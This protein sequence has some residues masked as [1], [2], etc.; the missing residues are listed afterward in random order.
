M[1][2][3]GSR[4]LRGGSAFQHELLRPTLQPLQSAMKHASLTEISIV[5]CCQENS[6]LLARSWSLHCHLRNA[7]YAN[8]S[9]D[10]AEGSPGW[11]YR[12]T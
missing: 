6:S 7:P 1:I 2:N 11:R 4:K 12:V 10:P 5:I 3:L 8:W 9:A